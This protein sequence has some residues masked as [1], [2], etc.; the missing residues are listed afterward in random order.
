MTFMSY[1]K[2]WQTIGD[3]N[4]Q[5]S[6]RLACSN[7]WHSAVGSDLEV[8]RTFQWLLAGG[9]G[10]L[11][12]SSLS[13]LQPGLASAPVLHLLVWP[14]SEKLY[15]RVPLQSHPSKSLGR[16]KSTLFKL[17]LR[18]FVT[19]VRKLANRK[20]ATIKIWVYNLS[21]EL[22]KTSLLIRNLRL[23]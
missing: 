11:K 17:G 16:G 19:V 6:S 18:H 13:G 7:T 10:S 15:L 4:Q 12:G 23:P 1:S 8:Y 9:G 3:L 22:L 14:L 2:V 5:C 21:V 20:Q